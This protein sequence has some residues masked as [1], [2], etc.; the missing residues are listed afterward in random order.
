MGWVCNGTVDL[1]GV[2]LY[3]GRGKVHVVV[4]WAKVWVSVGMRQWVQS[5]LH[6]IR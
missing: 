1:Q 5:N 3:V 2:W 4:C 6:S